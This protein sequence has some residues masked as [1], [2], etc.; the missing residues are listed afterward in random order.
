[1]QKCDWQVCSLCAREKK[2]RSICYV[3]HANFLNQFLEWFFKGGKSYEYL[4]R[5]MNG[6]ALTVNPHLGPWEHWIFAKL[7]ENVFG[8]CL[9]L[10]SLWYIITPSL[11]SAAVTSFDPMQRDSKTLPWAVKPTQ[12]SQILLACSAAQVRFLDALIYSSL[13]LYTPQYSANYYFYVG[14]GTVISL[15]D[16]F[17]SSSWC[18]WFGGASL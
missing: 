12:G 11:L 5:K 4:V 3:S 6:S 14:Q 16:R 1:M 18:W 7:Q 10:L 2:R 8:F 17:V 9:D 13:F 15:I